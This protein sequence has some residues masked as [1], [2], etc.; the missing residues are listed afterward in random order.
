MSKFFKRFGIPI[1][2]WLA[3]IATSPSE[4]TSQSVLF[5]FVKIAENYVDSDTGSIPSSGSL[6]DG[7]LFGSLT[8]TPDAGATIGITDLSFENIRTGDPVFWDPYTGSGRPM[9][10]LDGY[11]T[12]ATDPIQYLA[13]FIFANDTVRALSFTAILYYLVLI[14]VFFDLLSWRFRITPLAA[15]AGVLIVLSSRHLHYAPNH[16]IFLG[17]YVSLA[18]FLY[19]SSVLIDTN[20]RPKTVF[21]WSVVCS[22]FSSEHL[23]LS[24][25]PMTLVGAGVAIALCIVVTM[26]KRQERMKLLV[27]LLLFTILMITLNFPRILLLNQTASTSTNPLFPYLP[28]SV[29]FV[30]GVKQ[31]GNVLPFGNTIYGLMIWAV[32]AISGLLKLLRRNRTLFF[33]I[34]PPFIFSFLLGSGAFGSFL[35]GIGLN[36]QIPNV[37]GPVISFIMAFL[38]VT[39]VFVQTSS[40]ELKTQKIL[41]FD[42]LTEKKYLAAIVI[43]LSLFLSP[44]NGFQQNFS[45]LFS[46]FLCCILVLLLI[47]HLV[48]IIK[49]DNSHAPSF[50]L[51]GIVVIGVLILAVPITNR[52]YGV[53]F[54]STAAR[55]P[56][57]PEILRLARLANAQNRFVMLHTS[58][59]G[60][61][62]AITNQNTNEFLYYPSMASL[63]R[64]YEVGGGLSLNN[65]HYSNFLDS[66]NLEKGLTS[67]MHP[68]SSS[69]QNKYQERLNS[70][71]QVSPD[72]QVI[73]QNKRNNLLVSNPN[74]S[75]LPYVGAKYVVSS[76]EVSNMSNL[77][78]V[79]IVRDYRNAGREMKLSKR[80][81]NFYIYE[82]TE[83]LPRAYFATEIKQ[84][85][86]SE[87]IDSLLLAE[88]KPIAIIEQAST[89]TIIDKA[90]NEIISITDTPNRTSIRI[91]SVGQSFLVL[92]DVF[93]T[94]WK[95]YLDGKESEILR[96]NYAFRGVVV[97][98]GTR[99]VEFV[100]ETKVLSVYLLLKKLFLVS[101]FMI[102]FV[103][104][105][106]RIMQTYAKPNC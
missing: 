69:F 70:G 10:P 57:P 55:A 4:I 67:P 59:N 42:F 41:F 75:L 43:L 26:L 71:L 105:Y 36:I 18:I 32:I 8:Y 40:T 39:I 83:T 63:F 97:P 100:L 51:L 31:I 11:S 82:I 76:F 65:L 103:T 53:E 54:Q 34:L 60:L 45:F 104:V 58:D 101:L 15:S 5:P 35:L 52:F 96:T 19:C 56:L 80:V 79:D 6:L 28:A 89:S 49:A 48:R 46:I 2:I 62:G 24:I 1:F 47:Y 23:S 25:L 37:I 12:G 66:L 16:L 7:V 38:L 17:V 81:E 68:A 20:S 77:R 33:S 73:A 14:L 64:M 72:L 93:D 44:F 27:G 74:S 9:D 30:D 78:L 61:P 106:K 102:I 90:A 86:D 99:N 95:V 92:S 21:I 94:R 50:D 87:T 3:F 88:R 85:L 22:Y 29:D 84:T 91:K 98:S 13:S